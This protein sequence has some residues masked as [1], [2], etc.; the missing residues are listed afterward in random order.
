MPVF[1]Y[2]AKDSNKGIVNGTLEAESR[3]AVV[4]RLQSMG[5]FPI[6]VIQSESGEKKTLGSALSGRQRIKSSDMSD[7]YRQMSDLIGSGVP[8]VKSLSIVKAQTPNPTLQEILGQINS[9]VQGGDT[10]AKA[11]EKHPKLFPKLPVAL[12]RAGETGGLLDQTLSRIADFAEAQDELKSK[13][14][15]ALAY[16][17]IMVIV[18]VIV[19]TILLTFVMP[20]IIDIF[21]DLDQTLPAITQLLIDF[22]GFLRGYWWTIIGALVV[23]VVAF[24]K[25]IATEAGALRY[26]F[27]LLRIP[28]LGDLLLKR[29]LAAFARTL[30]ALLGN[31]VPILNALAISAEVTTLVPVRQEIEKIPD[32]ITQGSGMASSLRTSDV[33]PPVVVNIVAIGEETGRLPEVL[34]RVANSYEVQVDRAIKTAT[35]FI[36]P[37]VIVAL[38]LVVGTIVIAMLL[39]VFSIDPTTG[40]Q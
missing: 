24:R 16:P 34:L 25:Y 20:K 18:G 8:L 15:A 28:L 39:P 33:F 37:L 2:K 38:A 7:F 21:K 32:A 17:M 19:V 35:S 12:V 6:E 9:D 27:S 1:T 31:G 26:H 40:L 23:G 14:K 36:E 29:E 22:S 10:F 13:I 30:G 4:T 3:A 11:L 5:C